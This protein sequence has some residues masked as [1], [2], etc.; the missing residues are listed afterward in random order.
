MQ[1]LSHPFDVAALERS[2]E[3]A[4]TIAATKAMRPY[5]KREVAP[6]R[7]LKGH[8]LVDFV[9]NGAT[10]YFHS[11]GA[12]R[13]GKDDRAVVDAKLRVN[14][15]HNLRIADSTIMPRIVSAPTMPACVLIGLRMVEILTGRRQRRADA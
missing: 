9:R 12:C 4:R 1:F 7:A 11:S 6:G 10:T 13:M 3:L 14:G 5:V 2:I 15:V 8:E